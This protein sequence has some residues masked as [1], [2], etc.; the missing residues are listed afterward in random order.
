M[1]D[2]ESQTYSVRG[3]TCEHC[4]AAVTTEV[5]GVEGVEH[6]EVDLDSG[7]VQVRGAGFSDDQVAAAVA[8]AGYEMVP[9]AS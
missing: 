6:V 9:N 3:M 1:S 2:S 4:Q 7:S 5:M 8:E